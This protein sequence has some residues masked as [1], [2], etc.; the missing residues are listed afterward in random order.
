MAP[1]KATLAGSVP[2]GKGT[3]G[4]WR[5]GGA[6]TGTETTGG[7]GTHSQMRRAPLHRPPQSSR[8]RRAATAVILSPHAG[9]GKNVSARRAMAYAFFG[10]ML[11]P[12]TEGTSYGTR[13]MYE[14]GQARD[15]CC[16][17]CHP[18]HPLA[19]RP[20]S[21]RSLLDNAS[22]VSPCHR[23]VAVDVLKHAIHNHTH[24][25]KETDHGDRYL[26]IGRLYR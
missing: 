23:P 13:S 26:H 25:P 2:G 19:L 22:P 10:V 1:R 7:D 21:D 20:A 24:D 11:G 4:T 16:P 6:G 3:A 18:D 17:R 12:F 5:G 9:R 15:P 8:N 14:A